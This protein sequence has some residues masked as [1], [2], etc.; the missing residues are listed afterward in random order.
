LENRT[1]SS[2]EQRITAR[3][4]DYRSSPP[5]RRVIADEQ[6]HPTTDLS[7]IFDELAIP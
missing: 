3:L 2:F 7:A 1:L 5:A 4:P 6:G